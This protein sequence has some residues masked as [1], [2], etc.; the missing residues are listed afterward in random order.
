MSGELRMTIK[1]WLSVVDAAAGSLGSIITAFSMK[2]VIRES[3]IAR[4]GIETTVRV[5][6]S[7]QL[8]I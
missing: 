4:N 5:L 3:T 6:A 1:Q 7:N 2:S 8:N